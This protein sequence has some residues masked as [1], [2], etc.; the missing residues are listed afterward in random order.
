MEQT[1]AAPVEAEN[2]PETTPDQGKEVAAAALDTVPT[3]SAYSDKT[4]FEL[5]QRIAKAVGASDLVPAQF[6]GTQNLPNAMR[7][8]IQG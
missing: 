2:L 3:N 1:E 4:S 8:L 6:R 5:T 7:C